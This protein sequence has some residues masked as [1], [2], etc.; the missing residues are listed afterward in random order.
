MEAAYAAIFATNRT[1]SPYSLTRGPPRASSCLNHRPEPAK[2]RL[3]VAIL[4]IGVSPKGE[5]HLGVEG[6]F[7]LSEQGW[8]PFSSA[9]FASDTPDL[10]GGKCKRRNY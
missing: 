2:K 3:E 1:F 10:V 8:V 7:L 9:V 6:P 4:N 5:G